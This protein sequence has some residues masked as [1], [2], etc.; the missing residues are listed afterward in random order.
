MTETFARCRTH[1]WTGVKTPSIDQL[2]TEGWAKNSVRHRESMQKIYLQVTDER[3]DA[4]LK[5]KP[6]LLPRLGET[7]PSNR[8]E[9]ET[10]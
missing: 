7:N 2:V 4:A 3:R 10:V 6:E 1:K 8:D 5:V 9:R